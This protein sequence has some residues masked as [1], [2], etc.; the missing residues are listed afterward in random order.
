MPRLEASVDRWKHRPVAELGEQVEGERDRGGGV[1]CMDHDGVAQALDH[2]GAVVVR[3][4]RRPRQEVQGEVRCRFVPIL[5]RN[6]RIA[7]DVR[8]EKRVEVWF[9]HLT[10]TG[11]TIRGTSL[12]RPDATAA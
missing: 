7:G 1:L 6:E 10:E 8:E 2:L 9:V 11:V 3:D 12:L 4:A 5:I